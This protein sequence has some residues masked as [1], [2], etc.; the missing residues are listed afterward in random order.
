[1][2]HA[3]MR[4]RRVHPPVHPPTRPFVFCRCQ[5]SGGQY[6]NMFGEIDTTSDPM[7][8]PPNRDFPLWDSASGGYVMNCEFPLKLVNDKSGT[9]VRLTG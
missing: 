1:M 2:I 7:Q 6:A 3:F 8:N 9:S 5:F 4:T